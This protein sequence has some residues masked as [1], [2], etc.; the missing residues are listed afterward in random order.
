MEKTGRY[1]QLKT[2]I[3]K[4]VLKQLVLLLSS[5]L[6]PVYV[7][8]YV[9]GIVLVYIALQDYFNLGFLNWL[10]LNNLDFGLEDLVWC[11]FV[12]VFIYQVII[13]IFYFLFKKKIDV[14][15]RRE[16]L[17][18]VL[19]IFVLYF[20][21]I[22]AT[23]LKHNYSDNLVLVF[24]IVIACLGILYAWFFV[25]ANRLIDE[26]LMNVDNIKSESVIRYV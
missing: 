1:S 9:F 18:N 14:S 8:F 5:V 16:V 22:L 24:M 2:D 19:L 13:N 23:I 10:W 15:L 20:F 11:Y 6:V 25:V 12:F 17:I 4:F 3:L 21:G 7:F 26:L